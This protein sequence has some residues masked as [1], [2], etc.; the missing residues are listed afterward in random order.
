[1][2]LISLEERDNLI[3]ILLNNHY[4]QETNADYR[5][6]LLENSNLGK[7]CNQLNLEMPFNDFVQELCSKL[8]QEINGAENLGIIDFLTY[9]LDLNNEIFNFVDEELNYLQ[10]IKEEVKSRREEPNYSAVK[11]RNNNISNQLAEKRQQF[12]SNQQISQIIKIDKSEIAKFDLAKAVEEFNQKVVY[13]GTS[14]FAVVADEILLN[15]M[16][17]RIRRELRFQTLR[18]NK[19]IDIYLP[20]NLLTPDDFE[21][22]FLRKFGCECFADVFD[23]QENIDILVIA[24]Y[25]KL[26]SVKVQP[27]AQSFF[28]KLSP[29]I[30]P[31]LKSQKRCFVILWSNVRGKPLT[32][33]TLL[34]TPRYSDLSQIL[35]FFETRLE[36]AKLEKNLQEEYLR[37]LKSEYESKDV[38][39]IYREINHIIEELQGGSQ[40]YE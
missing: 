27:V 3:R 40:R 29:R 13:K 37:R 39:R 18:N 7:Y 9:I 24:R 33:F 35:N 32:A 36:S 19:T 5:R 14:A 4:L 26:S 34:P 11:Q 21:Q 31:I 20:K 2:I 8:F 38:G 15:Y 30:S 17:E 1:M 16:I 12:I 10:K 23:P 25:D 6:A 22:E 28:E